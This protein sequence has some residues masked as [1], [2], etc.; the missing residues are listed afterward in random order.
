MNAMVAVGGDHA[1]IRSGRVPVMTRNHRAFT[2]SRRPLP[3]SA[4]AQ[5]ALYLLPKAEISALDEI[6]ETRYHLPHSRGTGADEVPE[7]FFAR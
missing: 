3:R 6:G 1:I 4:V 5:I 7:Q 2:M